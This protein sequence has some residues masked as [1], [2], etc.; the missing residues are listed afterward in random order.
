MDHS[1]PM[2][3]TQR[4]NCTTPMR[5]VEE[6]LACIPAR[7]EPKPGKKMLKMRQHTPVD[8]GTDGTCSSD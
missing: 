5:T 6:L 3:V 1:H 8:L 4:K 2:S 7:I